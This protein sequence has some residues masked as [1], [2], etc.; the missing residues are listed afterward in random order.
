[1][2]IR[3][4]GL[5]EEVDDATE[6]LKQVVHVIDDS[7]HRPLRGDSRLVFVYLDVRL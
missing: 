3:L 4:M 5:P 2:K 1:M 6:R 7:G